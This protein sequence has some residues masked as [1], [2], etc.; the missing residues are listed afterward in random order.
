[1][2]DLLARLSPGSARLLK[3]ATEDEIERIERIAERPLP[4]FYRWFLTRMGRDMGPFAYPTLDCSVA[5]ILEGYAD[6]EFSPDPHYLM[7]GFET[8]EMMPLHLCYDF[9][10]PLRGD[11]RVVKMEDPEDTA[12]L[13]SETFRE[14]LAWGKLFRFGVQPCAQRCDGVFKVAAEDAEIPS[15]IG[16]LVE[17]IGF[18]APEGIL[19]GAYCSLFEHTDGALITSSVPETMPRI[20]AFQLGGRN[21]AALRRILGE[22]SAESDVEVE[23]GEWTPALP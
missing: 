2:D 18:R 5:A 10:H 15:V 23:I 21:A 4:D 8:N 6:E 3:G 14:M 20:H 7:I 13:E 16:P 12:L 1:M 17:S 19:T 11:A 9:E 22:I